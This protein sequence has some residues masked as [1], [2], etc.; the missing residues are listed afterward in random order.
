MSMDYIRNHYD[1]PAKRGMKVIV[2]GK[3]GVITAADGQYLRIR[4]DGTKRSGIYH[5]TDRIEYLENNV[6]EHVD[7]KIRYG[8]GAY[9]A[10]V[11]GKKTAASSSISPFLAGSA[12]FNKLHPGERIA[13]A[14]TLDA[15][16]SDKPQVMRF[17]FDPSGEKAALST[18][19]C[20]ASGH[21]DFGPTLPE[22]AIALALGEEQ[23]VRDILTVNARLSRHDN[24]TLFVPG[25]P[26]AVN[27]REGLKAVAH[28]I[29]RLAMSNQPG[30]RALGA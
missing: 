2:Y 22:G 20:F 3:P 26:E 4:L 17:T 30:F 21:I 9:H 14:E 13:G 15:G 5:P 24:E 23:L 10:S 6:M 19:F 29:Q 27:Q 16:S 8:V 11:A 12:L 18:A 1:V 28:F 7:I 25:V